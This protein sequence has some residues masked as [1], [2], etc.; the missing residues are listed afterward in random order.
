MVNI[1]VIIKVLATSFEGKLTLLPINKEKYISFIE[2][3]DNTNVKLKFIDSFR[4]MPSNLEKLASYLTYDE[5]SIT[6]KYCKMM[7]NLK[8]SLEKVFF[9]MIISSDQI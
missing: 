2:D 3:V 8:Y 5:K 9:H 4:F 1:V 6:K 7:R